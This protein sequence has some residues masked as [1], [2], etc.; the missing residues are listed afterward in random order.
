[1]LNRALDEK[2][3]ILTDLT[4]AAFISVKANAWVRVDSVDAGATVETV[5]VHAIIDIC[6][7]KDSLY[8]EKLQTL[9]MSLVFYD[10]CQFA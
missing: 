2:K 8:K 7:N 1:M 10:R 3:T 6:E 5:D 9:N 4:I